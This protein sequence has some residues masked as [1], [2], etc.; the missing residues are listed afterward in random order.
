M[1]KSSIFNARRPE[2]STATSEHVT[3]PPDPEEDADVGNFVLV[4]ADG[5][6]VGAGAGLLQSDSTTAAS[7]C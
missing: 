3:E 6:F 7:Q 4:A 2:T 5:N 1:S